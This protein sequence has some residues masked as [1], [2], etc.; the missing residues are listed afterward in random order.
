MTFTRMMEESNA[1][2]GQIMAMSPAF[3]SIELNAFPGIHDS[4]PV[5]TKHLYNIY[6]TSAQRLRR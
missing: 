1:S 2:S 4:H 5:K 6:T 3:V